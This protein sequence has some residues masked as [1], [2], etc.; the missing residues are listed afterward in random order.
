VDPAA[1]AARAVVFVDDGADE[2]SGAGGGI[3]HGGLFYQGSGD[4]TRM[5]LKNL[6]ATEL[7]LFKAESL[8][9]GD[10]YFY[11]ATLGL[12]IR[13]TFELIGYVVKYINKHIV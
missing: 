4:W 2:V 8:R 7:F 9:R 11:S 6:M 5:S 10:A 13:I 12:M 1:E 3:G